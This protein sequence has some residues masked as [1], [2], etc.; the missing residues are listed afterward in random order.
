MRLR[1]LIRG[2][3]AAAGDRLTPA[4]LATLATEQPRT[5]RSVATVATVAG[6]SQPDTWPSLMRGATVDGVQ[7]DTAASLLES[8]VAAGAID[9][10]LRLGWDVR[11]LIGLQRFRPYDHPLRAGLSFSLRPDDV[12][13]DVSRAGC[14]IAYGN[15]RHI[16]RR[17]PL[18]ASIMLPWDLAAWLAERGNHAA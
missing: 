17:R 6:Y 15:V 8:L 10:A 12:V 9:A 1:H 16:W 7:L 5:P 11:E 2:H 14:I 13:Q 4:T 3:A 18:D